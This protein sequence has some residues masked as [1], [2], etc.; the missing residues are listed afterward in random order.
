VKYILTLLLLIIIHN[1]LF[2]IENK[3]SKTEF[4]FS[5]VVNITIYDFPE[6]E[7]KKL[8]NQ[9]F[10]MMRDFDKKYN[11]TGDNIIKRINSLKSGEVFIL[12]GALLD[13]M[14]IAK[15]NYEISD[16]YYDITIGILSELYGF[17]GEKPH[18]PPKNEILKSLSK[19]G[20]DK[21][22]FNE[23]TGE[24]HFKKGGVKI[25]IGGLAKGYIIERVYKFLKDNG[26]KSALINGGG[27]IKVLGNKR[28]KPFVIGVADPKDP[29]FILA[30]ITLKDGESVASSGD[31]E[32]FFIYQNKRYCHIFN[33]KSGYP[34]LF[35]H[36]STVI[37][38]SSTL[39]EAL[40]LASLLMKPSE[41]LRYIT[42][43]GGMGM[44]VTDDYTPIMSQKFI[45]RCKLKVRNSKKDYIFLI[46]VFV[47]IIISFILSSRFKGENSGFA[48]LTIEDKTIAKIDL[49]QN[50]LYEFAAPLG[51]VSVEV[52]DGKIAII[53]SPC[54]NKKCV[55]HG[56]SSTGGD[57]IV[58]APNKLSILIEKKEDRIDGVTK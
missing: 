21:I 1:P 27:D 18:L 23:K 31:Y 58:C 50:K 4:L 44:V 56:F 37:A 20:F 5:T 40:S 41:A 51:K 39:A 35:N 54:P 38:K 46:F 7:A 29:G 34:D 42:K 32:R 10:D 22:F 11:P 43:N 13:M 2:G 30:T 53:D 57:M 36:G 15:R 16:G 19:V 55:K 25:D 48:I 33:P 17:K 26:V 6:A 9:S 14:K 3:I 8:L 24:F 52:K 12:S 47:T 28:G 49:S 45:G